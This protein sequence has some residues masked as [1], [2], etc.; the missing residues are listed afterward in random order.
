MSTRLPLLLMLAVLP[1]LVHAL[2][3]GKLQLDSALNEPFEARIELVSATVEELDS[4]NVRLADEAAF[5]RADIP[6]PHFLTTLNFVLKQTDSGPDYI[7][8]YTDDP[9]REPFLNFLL[10]I[11]WAKGRLYREYTVLLDPPIYAD[12]KTQQRLAQ[13][14]SPAE[15]AETTGT[16]SGVED[17]KV[18]YNPEYT[19]PRTAPSAYSAAPAV[20]QPI[21]YSG[22]DYGPTIS[23]DTLWSIASAMRPDSSISVQQM[24]FAL[25]R[26]NPEAF[27]NGNINGLKRGHVLKMPDQTDVQ[28]MN[29]DQ[30]FAEAKSQNN[31]WEEARQSMAAAVTPRP[32]ST[33]PV[34]PEVPPEPV[35]EPVATEPEPEVQP[36]PVAEAPVETT[37]PV[38]TEPEGE[39][40]LR[41]VAPAEEGEA[42]GAAG[43][44]GEQLANELALA[45]ESLEA[46]TQENLELKDKLSETEAI[47]D[48]LNR[49][50][51]LKETELAALQQKIKEQEAAAAEAAVPAAEGPTAE[52]TAAEPVVEQPAPT[53]DEQVPA[54]TPAQEAPPTVAEE[55]AAEEQIPAETEPATTEEQKPAAEAAEPAVE[56]PAPAT[57]AFPPAISGFVQL[58]RNNAT[59]AGAGLG[60]LVLI[61][62]IAVMLKRRQSASAMVIPQSA[63]PDFADESPSSEDAT[64]INPA[65]AESDSEAPTLLPGAED[66]TVTPEFGGGD[67]A[68]QIMPSPAQ[69]D[70]DAFQIPAAEQEEDPLHDVNIFLA[71][72]Q[73]DQAEQF[74]KKMIEKDP[75]NLEFHSKLLEVYYAAN[76]KK[77]YENAARVLH[78]KVNGKGDYWNM[79]VAMWQEISPNREL[80]AK[81][82][83][84]EEE[85]AGPHTEGGG[86]VNI[87]GDGAAGAGGLDFDLDTTSG[88]G[89]VLN[90]TA[91]DQE[92]DVLDVTAA[93]D[94][95][96]A[97]V[98]DATVAAAGA[99]GGMA[100]DEEALDISL[101]MSLPAEQETAQVPAKAAD[102]NSLDFSLDLD[103]GT[104]V[105]SSADDA[106]ELSL[107]TGPEPAA[108]DNALDISLDMSTDSGSVADQGLEISLGAEQEAPAAEENN[109][110]DFSFELDKPDVATDKAEDDSL[111]VSQGAGTAE[112]DSGLE[113]SLD[114]GE[115]AQS[116]P[117]GSLEFSLDIPQDSG[118][119][120]VQ[121]AGLDI[122]LDV[123]QDSSAPAPSQ[124][125]SMDF[126]LDLDTSTSAGIQQDENVLDISLEQSPVA[127]ASTPDALNLSLNISDDAKG[128]VK[129]GK[130][131]LLDVTSAISLDDDF[132]PESITAGS[133]SELLDVTKARNFEPD[134]DQDLLDVTS[135]AATRAGMDGL[136]VL[137]VNKPGPDSS[138]N[139]TEQSATSLD[140][141]LSPDSGATDSAA[142]AGFAGIDITTGQD[143]SGDALELSLVID[144]KDNEAPE[145]DM[146]STM[147]IPNRAALHKHVEE[148]ASPPADEFSLVI[149][150]EDEEGADQTIMVPRSKTTAE[151]S[152][153]DE[154]ATQLDLAKAYLELGE[155]GNAK[156]I[157]DEVMAIGNAQQKQQA[158]ELLSQI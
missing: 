12:S 126:S 155:T 11:S 76:N 148:P 53:A 96:D 136:D 81:P 103:T 114:T 21:N 132:E 97:G 85:E 24:M 7:R 32:E 146:D 43:P 140:F 20:T 44:S 50:I 156:T 128:E 68:T 158:Q 1:G 5:S 34:E 124:D 92:A 110:L 83:S 93:V 17:N 73:F 135:A 52:E 141:E 59:Y 113:I 142:D 75:N 91:N 29:K 112:A 38:V 105:S 138:Q 157:L 25:L 79:A 67:D 26:A 2:G 66:E 9:I 133:S 111:D 99:Q 56:A 144:E 3:L 28:S 77:G 49:L 143:A 86:I 35:S 82:A 36:E 120:A 55:P 115:P 131:D 94:M 153:D 45:N 63:F 137:D 72:E 147:Q 13:A 74:V 16:I 108:D 145:I 47:I 22:G 154:I 89:E 102:D 106:L 37:E 71:Y 15:E 107:D 61:G 40:E 80:F 51:A 4:L 46:L 31:L 100:A 95:E 109:L 54:E 123:S 48:D 60:V 151:Q 149:D 90:M 10:E 134:N 70:P 84:G 122:S 30:A 117:D 121:D 42:E 127:A 41:L 98:L 101:D 58:L 39:P 19:Q 118:S 62:L 78:D 129:T 130:A 57:S 139:V 69:P 152:A 33:V 8:I 116:A 87:A 65:L 150:E 64:D 18:V 119:A 23:G 6:R 27:I 125:S 14:T 88:S 104:G